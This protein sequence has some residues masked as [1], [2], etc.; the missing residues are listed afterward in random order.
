MTSPTRSQAL[1]HA[2]QVFD[3]G[4]FRDTLARRVAWRTESQVPES[5]PQMGGYL[6]QELV[7]VLRGMGFDAQILPNPDPAG[8]PFL[9]AERHERDDAPTM[10]G[11][12]HADVVR[13]MAG[14]WSGDRDPWTLGVDGDRWYGRGTADNKSQHSINLQAMASVLAVRGSL[15]FNARLLIETGEEIGSPG[16]HAFCAAHRDRLA[17]DLLI[18]SDGPR[19]APDRPTMFLGARGAMDFD[20]TLAPR[21]NGQHSGNWGGALSNPGVRLANALA[22]IVDANGRVKVRG[23][24]PD[25]ILA[26]VREALAGCALDGGV[27]GPAVDEHWGEPG[28]TPAERVYAWNTFEVIAFETGDPR[29]PVNAIPPRAWARVQIRFTPDV[30]PETFEPTL[31]R[32]LDDAGFADITLARA[33]TA[34]FPATRVDP[35]HPRV[36]WAVESIERTLGVRPVVLPSLGGSLPNDC[37]AQIL[38]MPTLWFPHSYAGCSQHAPDEHV[39]APVLREGLAMMTGLFWDLGQ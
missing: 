9:V 18:A 22:S 25:A 23:L 11:Y 12:G 38:D 35:A 29:F 2:L 32:H 28:L 19:I 33:K 37:F 39:L 34:F 16:L 17:A 21:R 14:R 7:P 24:L 8:G 3:S 15:G 26:S 10:L 20:L 31:R 6:E 5:Q 13:G 36:R 4:A 1:A 27:D 30:P